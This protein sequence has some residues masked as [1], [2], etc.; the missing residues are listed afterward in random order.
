M[1]TV[2]T[3]MLK[4]WFYPFPSPSG[5]NSVILVVLSGRVPTQERALESHSSFAELS[6]EL[7]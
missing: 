7:F 3:S 2:I 5:C 1:S 6:R 4:N